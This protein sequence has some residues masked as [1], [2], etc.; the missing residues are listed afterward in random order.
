MKNKTK[1][2][3]EVFNSLD[4]VEKRMDEIKDAYKDETM[5]IVAS[6]PSLNNYA[7][8]K[9]KEILSDKLVV[10]IKQSY[11][12]L[13]DITDILLLNFTNLSPYTFN[14]NTIV[15]WLYWFQNHPQIV[16]EKFKGDLLFPIYRNDDIPNKM[17]QSIAYKGDYENMMFDKGLPRPWGPGLMYELGIPLAVHLGVKKIVTLGWDVGN[18]DLWEGQE[19]SERHFVDHYYSD[20]T[21]LFDRFKIDATEIKLIANSMVGIY[22]YLQTIGVEFNIISDRNPVGSEVPRIKLED[23]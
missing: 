4:S 11:H 10:C 16:F 23:I 9:L 3:L 13:K 14:P 15:T 12:Q 5:Y 2:I 21:Q 22:N 6:G 1:K 8:N 19:D 17:T 7:P 20:E 18:L